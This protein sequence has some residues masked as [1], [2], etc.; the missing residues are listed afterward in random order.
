[1]LRAPESGK[2]GETTARDFS[3]RAS[4]D[5]AAELSVERKG[6]EEA[7]RIG[8]LKDDFLANLSHELRTPINVILGW[9]QLMTPGET[10]VEEMAEGLQV[11]KRS[12]RQ[13]AQ[14]I[15]DLLD[16]SRVVSGKMRLDAQRVELPEVIDA[17]LESVKLAAVAKGIVIKK[18]ID[19]LAGPVTGDPARLQQVVWN[20]LINAVKFT[21][22]GGKVQVILERVNSHL[23]LSVSDTGRGIDPEFLPFVFERLSQAES[24]R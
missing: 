5:H 19:P 2:I 9:S 24:V 23:D 16:M 14:L 17:A 12:A 8:H 3:A 20:L 1:M 7:E 6:R 15:E 21:G 13:Q 11:I 4:A 10:S 18:V 22:Q